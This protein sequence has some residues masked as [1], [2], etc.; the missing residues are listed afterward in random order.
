MIWLIETYL[1]GVTYYIV[2]P[3]IAGLACACYL[4]FAYYRRQQEQLFEPLE[5]DSS[6]NDA[7][8]DAE[9]TDQEPLAE[10]NVAPDDNIET[11][12]SDESYQPDHDQPTKTTSND[13]EKPESVNQELLDDILT[14]TAEQPELPPGHIRTAEAELVDNDPL[15]FF[16]AKAK[17][18]EIHDPLETLL[19][20]TPA[21]IQESTPEPSPP[22]VEPRDAI[23][24]DLASLVLGKDFDFDK[25]AASLSETIETAMAETETTED[26]TTKSIIEPESVAA[27]K[28]PEPTSLSSKE[29]SV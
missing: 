3:A 13:S 4:Q 19:E 7:T 12:P 24:E 11:S 18:Q 28:T 21:A 14:G 6:E 25:L 15:R 5:T 8:A 17:E 2:L 20:R 27:I 9:S 16:E 1:P 22:A 26:T 29:E 10:T 23:G